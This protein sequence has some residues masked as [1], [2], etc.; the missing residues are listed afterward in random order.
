[1]SKYNNFNT[2]ENPLNIKDVLVEGEEIIWEGKPKKNV[3]ILNQIAVMFPFAFIWLLV[4]GGIIA[5]MIASGEIKEM[6]WFVIPFFAIHLMPVW[7]W[8]S[9]LLTA[10]KKWKNT[11]YALTNKRIIM[12]SGFIGVNYQ[13]IFYKD[14]KKVNLNVGLMDKL[15]KVGDL[16]FATDDGRT[17]FLDIEDCYELYPKIQKVVLDIQTDIEFPNNLRPKEND[18]YNTKYNGKI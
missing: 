16:Y 3:Y 14:I 10:N 9:N 12:S 5:M 1:M 13:T 2:K 4:D 17:A 8:L 18:G 11:V 7:I 15:F 6:L